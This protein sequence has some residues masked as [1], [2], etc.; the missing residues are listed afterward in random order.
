MITHIKNRGKRLFPVNSW[1]VLVISIGIIPVSDY[2]EPVI[3]KEIASIAGD[4][5]DKNI[6]ESISQQEWV[7]LFK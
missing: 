4:Y 2:L 1:V 7:S 5:F 3:S 6:G